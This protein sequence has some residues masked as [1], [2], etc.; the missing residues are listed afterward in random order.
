MEPETHAHI[1]NCGACPGMQSILWEL[2]VCCTQADVRVMTGL[3]MGK[4][5]DAALHVSS[6]CTEQMTDCHCYEGAGL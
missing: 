5:R 4:W 3:P 6:H 1:L 2:R